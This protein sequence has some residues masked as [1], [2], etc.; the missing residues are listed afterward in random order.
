M[1]DAYSDLHILENVYY[2]IMKEILKGG[3]QFGKRENSSSRR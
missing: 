2:V 1:L 3:N